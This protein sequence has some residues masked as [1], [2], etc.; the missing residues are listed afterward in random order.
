[1]KKRFA[2]LLAGLVMIA[3]GVMIAHF[4]RTQAQA[5]EPG[6]ETGYQAGRVAVGAVFR[7]T[8]N[9][10]RCGHS[11]TRTVDAPA[12][13]TGLNNEGLADKLGMSWRVTD[14]SPSVIA[15]TKNV[16]LFCPQHV[17]LMPDAT[18][19]VCVWVNQYGDGMETVTET[20]YQLTDLDESER[21]AVRVGK[22]FDTREE[23]EG[24]LKSVAVAGE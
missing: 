1:M 8:I 6:V 10:Q 24:F 4:G 7:Q 12:A 18:G 20:D 16:M 23:A 15:M 19:Q 11:V 13:Y 5:Q 9:Y 3:A 22:A 14:F 2:I 17:V 21:E